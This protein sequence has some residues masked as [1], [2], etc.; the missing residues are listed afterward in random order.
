MNRYSTN[1]NGKKRLKEIQKQGVFA[2]RK[3]FLWQDSFQ[4]ISME[5]KGTEKA[6]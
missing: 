1:R 6:N 5:E 2:C 3:I 4:E